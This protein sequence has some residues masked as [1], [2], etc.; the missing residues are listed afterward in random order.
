MDETKEVLEQVSSEVLETMFFSSVLGPLEAPDGSAWLGAK[1]SFSGTLRGYLAVAAGEETARA[2][3]ESFLGADAD[4][5]PP[6]QVPAMLGELANVICGSVLG[7]IE[8]SGQ[9]VISAPE[10]APEGQVTAMLAN[11]QTRLDLELMEGGLS[12]GLTLS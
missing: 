6:E 8:E 2:L 5:V 7:K 4:D 10:A 1:V 12:V 3:A 11:L 9:F